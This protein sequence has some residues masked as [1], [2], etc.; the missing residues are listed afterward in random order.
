MWGSKAD[1]DMNKSYRKI[2][3]LLGRGTR[4]ES[5]EGGRVTG[6]HVDGAGAGEFA[7]QTFSAADAGDDATAGDALEH[8]LAVPGHEVAVVDDVALAVD[9]LVRGES[10]TGLGGE[11]GK[12]QEGEA[13]HG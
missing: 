11:G 1:V 5:L 3:Q 7:D 12:S 2:L 6:L 4:D 13:W 9:E 8:V 10:V